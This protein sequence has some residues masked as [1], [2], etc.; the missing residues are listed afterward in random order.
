MKGQGSWW[1]RT[2]SAAQG[3]QSELAV[4]SPG[5]R[6]LATYSLCT[7]EK[8]AFYN[9]AG[10]LKYKLEVSVLIQQICRGTEYKQPFLAFKY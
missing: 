8:V 1:A 6:G 5:T 4:L 2:G 3:S 7:N 9:I 10:I